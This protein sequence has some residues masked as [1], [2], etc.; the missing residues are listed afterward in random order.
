[1]DTKQHIQNNIGGKVIVITGA[2]SG[3]GR[4]AAEAFSAAGCKVVLVAR[5]Q[6]GI[7][8]VVDICTNLGAVAIGISADVSVAKDVEK[9]AEKTLEHFGNRCLGEQR[10]SYGKW[11]IRR[12]TY[13]DS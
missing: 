6:H 9:I 11:Q 5:G 13:G 7:D 4:A 1:M 10:R 8:E 2:S 12:D 3:V